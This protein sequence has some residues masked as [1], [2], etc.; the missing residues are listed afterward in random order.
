MDSYCS[1]MASSTGTILVEIQL[2]SSNQT[3]Q[4]EVWITQKCS[5]ML[6]KVLLL[7]FS[8]CTL[9]VREAFCKKSD[10]Q[11]CIDLKFIYVM[12]IDHW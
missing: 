6:N 9:R 2:G 10:V 8:V 11:T 3:S 1:I 5:G 12:I 7:G 4:V